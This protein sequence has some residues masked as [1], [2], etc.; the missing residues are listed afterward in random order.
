MNNRY[1]MQLI[2]LQ[3]GTSWVSS[4]SSTL[5]KFTFRTFFMV[6]K[7]V[8]WFHVIEMNFFKNFSKPMRPKFPTLSS[9]TCSESTMEIPEQCMKFV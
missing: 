6:W 8:Q 1:K 7:S 9:F 4:A 3:T 2:E 5:K